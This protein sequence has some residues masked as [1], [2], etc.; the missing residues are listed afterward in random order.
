MQF[1]AKALIHQ[2]FTLA[3]HSQCQSLPSEKG[4]PHDGIIM[5]SLTRRPPERALAQQCAAL[6]GRTTTLQGTTLFQKVLLLNMCLKTDE[7]LR[8]NG[9]IL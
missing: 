7:L 3:F 8:S 5:N 1:G 6:T 9:M 2:Q 4:K